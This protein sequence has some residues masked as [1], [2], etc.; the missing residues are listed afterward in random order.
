MARTLDFLTGKF[1]E[2]KKPKRKRPEGAVGEAVDNFLRGLGGYVRQ[3]NSGGV[4]RN[5]RYTTSG[6]GAGISDRLA[7]LPNGKCIAVELKAKGKKRTV[8]DAQYAFLV[9]LISRGHHAC[10]AD[11]V[12]DVKLCLSQS[13]NQMLA[14]L[15]SL[16]S[17]CHPAST[18]PLFP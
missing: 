17:R 5:G 6:Q 9:G 2:E 11:S 8:S 16:K 14:T 13:G 10:V 7:W 12:E 3:I 4:M 1:T 15:D 18:D